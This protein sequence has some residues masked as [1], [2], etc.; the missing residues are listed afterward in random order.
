MGSGLP[1]IGRGVPSRASVLIVPC[2]A[3][4]KVAPQ[5]P[6]GPTD[7]CRSTHQVTIPSYSHTSLGPNSPQHPHTMESTEADPLE[8]SRELRPVCRRWKTGILPIIL[9]STGWRDMLLS[10]EAPDRT[11]SELPDCRRR[12][13]WGNP[14]SLSPINW[15]I[16]L[17]I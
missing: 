6:T 15:L 11:T 13:I 5:G 12:A 3:A 16:P 2:Q 9:C 14:F 17:D 7:F 4:S 1:W 8:G 10:R